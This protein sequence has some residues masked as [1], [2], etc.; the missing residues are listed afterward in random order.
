MKK[1]KQTGLFDTYAFGRGQ[2]KRPIETQAVRE[3]DELRAPAA[4]KGDT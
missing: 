4:G 2:G 3:H 1:P